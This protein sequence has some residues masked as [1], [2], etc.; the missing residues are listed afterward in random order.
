MALSMTAT[1][2][3]YPLGALFVLVATCAVLAA[4][5]APL[6]R[7]AEGEEIDTRALA[8]SVAVG[9][10]TGL[11]VGLLVGLLQFRRLLGAVLGSSAGL[12]IGAA[13]GAMAMVP[14]SRFATAAAAMTAGSALIIAVA[15]IM[16]R[17]EP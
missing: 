9:T 15:L 3:G 8:V 14:A 17:V 7:L 12:V 13:S 6:V 5:I 16:R 2:Q 10:G 4:G 11:L 1:R